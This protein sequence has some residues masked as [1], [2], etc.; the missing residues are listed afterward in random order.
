[1]IALPLVA[2]LVVLGIA[3]VV[4]AAKAISQLAAAREDADKNFS[5]CPVGSPAQTCPLQGLSETEKADVKQAITDAKSMLEKTKKDIETWDA[6]TQ[7]RAQ[8]W[9]GDSSEATQQKMFDRTNK[10][11]DKLNK[12]TPEN[13]QHVEPGEDSKVYAYVYPNDDTKIYLGDSFADA[14][15]TGKDS[16]AGTL[17]HEISHF[18]SV[19]GTK[20]NAYGTKDSEDLA[21]TDSAAAQDNADSFEYFVEGQ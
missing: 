17:I 9:F 8:K 20:D 4:A 13:F 21:K 16:K 19:G 10:E 1:M 12:L 6:A 2:G 7:A 11:L 15:A 14:P 18:D 3:I 5:T